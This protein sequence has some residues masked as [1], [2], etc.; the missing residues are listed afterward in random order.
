MCVWLNRDERTICAY[1]RRE[2]FGFGFGFG[3]CLKEETRRFLTM[4]FSRLLESKSMIIFL[5]VHMHMKS[6][7]KVSFITLSNWK[8]DVE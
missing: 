2:L 5:L 7:T 8:M 1:V 3:V 4:L 6:K